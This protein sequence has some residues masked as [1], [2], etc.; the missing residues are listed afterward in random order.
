MGTCKVLLLGMTQ[1]KSSERLPKSGMET[2]KR[3]YGRAGGSGNSNRTRFQR[4]MIFLRFSPYKVINK[5]L[6]L[7]RI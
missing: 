5:V 4:R 2:G 1:E 7:C 3:E 6:F